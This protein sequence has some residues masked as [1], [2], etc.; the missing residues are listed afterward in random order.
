MQL[1]AFIAQATVADSRAES[2]AAEAAGVLETLSCRTFG[3]VKSPFLARIFGHRRATGRSDRRS[4]PTERLDVRAVPDLASRKSLSLDVRPSGGRVRSARYQYVVSA[5]TPKDDREADKAA[6]ERDIFLEFVA[7]A[8]LPVVPGSIES[9]RPPEP[10][11]VCELVGGGRVA[12]EVVEL[13]DQDLAGTI[14]RAVKRPDESRGVCF[15]DPTLD[16]IRGKLRRKYETLH[17]ME[18]L[19]VGDDLMLPEDVWRPK[20]EQ[21]LKD[22]L[23]GSSFQRL[24]VAKLSPRVAN[25]AV[26]LV[27]PPL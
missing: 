4:K 27:R 10:D 13:I 20:Y 21:R 24:W 11:I 17:P 8:G 16:A 6:R 5:A 14:A 15:G 2:R 3:A 9:R 25:R 23:D 22:L 18:L 7:V 1:V 19:A 26:L 12:F